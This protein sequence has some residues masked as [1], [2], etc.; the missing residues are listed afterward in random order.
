MTTRYDR[1]VHCGQGTLTRFISSRY[2]I[3]WGNS[4]RK[5]E[6]AEKFTSQCDSSWAG[7]AR[8]IARI[9]RRFISGHMVKS[10]DAG[11]S[12]VEDQTSRFASRF[13]GLLL[14]ILALQSNLQQVCGLSIGRRLV[15]GI[16]IAPSSGA[17]HSSTRRDSCTSAA[18]RRAAAAAA[19]PRSSTHAPSCSALLLPLTSVWVLCRQATSLTNQSHNSCSSLAPR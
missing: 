15:A 3:D 6:G 1:D 14:Q 17:T 19:D 10:S 18:H 13:V 11:T 5:A 2:L 7:H 9:T 12:T 4:S 8:S 16:R